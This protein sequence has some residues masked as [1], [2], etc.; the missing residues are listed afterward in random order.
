MAGLAVSERPVLALGHEQSV[1]PQT[2]PAR[3]EARQH[4]CRG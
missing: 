2:V 4:G 3:E 1:A